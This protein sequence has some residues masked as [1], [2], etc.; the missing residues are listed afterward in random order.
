M[1][2]GAL[3]ALNDLE[4]LRALVRRYPESGYL[5]GKAEAS[6]EGAPLLR[7][8]A[9]AYQVFGA[10]V[11]VDAS[12]IEADRTFLGL[13]TLKWVLTDRY[14]KFTSLQSMPQRLRRGSFNKL[15][16]YT[17]RIISSDA[18]LEFCL[19]SLTCNDLGKTLF[20]VEQHQK[21]I[22]QDADN[23][24]LLLYR[25]T[26]KMP[27][28][29]PA[30]QSRLT[31]AQQHSYLAGLG[32]DLNLGQFVQGEN[33][34]VNLA[35]MQALDAKSRE[36][37]L[38]CELFDFAGVTGHLNAE[39]SISMREDNYLA[40]SAAIAE[41]TALPLPQ[42][43]QR[44]IHYRGTLTGIDMSTEDGYALGRLTALSRSFTSDQGA[45]LQT[46]WRGL[47][48]EQKTVLSGELNETGD[49]GRK[50]ILLYYAPALIANAIAATGNYTA[51]LKYSLPILAQV[52][53]T[54]RAAHPAQSG[55]GVI[56]VNIA[57]L[58][59]DAQQLTKED[60]TCKT[61]L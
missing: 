36:L 57:K 40:F 59:R 33:L 15:R 21:I 44:Y 9:L 46:V 60:L 41:L 7:Q 42:A 29:F 56:T 8:D 25:L 4:F 5:A 58:A 52:Y 38:V 14:D 39:G 1:Q 18:D 55:N 24:D 12:A 34:P 30:F 49:N 50:G 54:A 28:L 32:A 43:Y 20:L 13:L 11:G 26:Q 53:Q 27:D 48:P 6:P 45:A 47:P 19:Y 61:P 22:G 16:R 35:G 37:R 23:H 17:T 10:N 3:L 2:T 31:P 51:G